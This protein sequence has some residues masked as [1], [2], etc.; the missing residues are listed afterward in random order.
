MSRIEVESTV[1]PDGVLALAI[2]IGPAEANLPVKIVVEP[3]AKANKQENWLRFIKETAGSIS[4]PTFK[5]QPQGDY[6]K[7]EAMD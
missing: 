5:R 1:G 6:E 4:D 3:L 7:R 2:P